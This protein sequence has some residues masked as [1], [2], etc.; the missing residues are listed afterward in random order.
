MKRTLVIMSIVLV[1][2]GTCYAGFDDFLKEVLVESGSQTI[3]A[4]EYV[5][6]P[7][8]PVIQKDTY[9]VYYAG[10]EITGNIRILLLDMVTSQGVV[11]L[12][13][14]NPEEIRI[15]D[16]RLNVLAFDNKSLRIRMI[17]R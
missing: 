16:Y 1:L 14:P 5:F 10:S 12:K 17:G 8:D 6:A 11:T 4:N 9:V 15:K 3:G 2:S 13:Y 7:G